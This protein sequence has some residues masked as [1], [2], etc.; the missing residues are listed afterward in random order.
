MFGFLRDRRR[1]KLLAGPF[2]PHW[3]VLLRRNVG[4]YPRLSDA[5]RAR[6]RDI[7]RV[8]VAEK[9]WEGAGGLT[10]TEE[11]RLT[12]AA[13]AGLLLLGL[14]HDYYDRVS[15]VVV[16]P[17]AFRTPVEEDG[18]E[19]DGLS[20][21]PLSGQAVYRG[22]VILS[23]DEALAEGREPAAGYNVVVHEFAHQLDFL[24]GASDGTPA[25]ADP[26]LA[27]RWGPTMQAAFETHRAALGRRQETFFTE[28]A[29]DDEAE[30]FA[31]ASEAFCC[32]PHDL[33][34]EE[35]GVFELLR[36]YY[37]LDPRAWFP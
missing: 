36:A 29:G 32:R 21:D 31:D 9:N 28:H 27:R 6:L 7:T 2:P 15:A 16:Y 33:A 5:E 37:K 13:Q 12:V 20:D 17:G 4:H 24:D 25:L 26:E 14:D 30:F 22:P 1:R 19:D 18:W 8:L 10:V 3:E 35:P 23:W 34:A 11:I